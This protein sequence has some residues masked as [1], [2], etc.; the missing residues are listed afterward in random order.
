[1]L[2][3]RTGQCLCGESCC[4]QHRCP[5]PSPPGRWCWK[6][7]K[8]IRTARQARLCSGRATGKHHDYSSLPNVFT[9][10]RGGYNKGCTRDFVHQ[11]RREVSMTMRTE[12]LRQ[13][14]MQEE[15]QAPLQHLKSNNRHG[16]AEC[17]SQPPAVGSS[18][19]DERRK[20]REQSPTRGVMQP[21]EPSCRNP[22]AFRCSERE[23]C[24]DWVEDL[25]NEAPVK[26]RTL[27]KTV[28]KPQGSLLYAQFQFFRPAEM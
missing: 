17:G 23:D 27:F 28:N 3:G 24:V 21:P 5:S 20:G 11:T 2:K 26:A 7:N 22:N 9:T 1:M 16:D 14:Q 6:R 12:V 8:S 13:D 18:R 10:K 19:C 25:E 4:E 15:T